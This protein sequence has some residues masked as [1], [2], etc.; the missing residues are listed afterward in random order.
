MNVDITTKLWGMLV[1]KYFYWVTGTSTVITQ[2]KLT[3]MQKIYIYLTKSLVQTFIDI[4]KNKA[5]DPLSVVYILQNW[6]SQITINPK[7]TLY[8]GMHK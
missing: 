6:L 8:T 3:S 4:K 7:Y 5:L 2:I 1:R